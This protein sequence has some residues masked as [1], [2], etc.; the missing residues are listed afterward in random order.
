M[1]ETH[2][3]GIAAPNR[4]SEEVYQAYLNRQ[5]L[6]S[7]G[8][9]EPHWTAAGDF[10]FVRGAPGE[11][12]ILRVNCESGEATPIFDAAAVRA[13]LTAATGGEPRVTVLPFSAFQVTDSG[14]I[15]FE[16]LDSRWRLDPATNQLHRLAAD[17][18][19]THNRARTWRRWDYLSGGVEVP[20]VLSP[21]GAWFAS[22]RKHDLFLRSAR[23]S[24]VQQLTHCGSENKFWDLEAGRFFR[25][26]RERSPASPWSADSRTLFAHR[27][28]ITEVFRKP[29]IHWLGPD[30][31]V[32]YYPYQKAGAKLDRLEPTFVDVRSG[33]QI[34]VSVPTADDCYIQLLTWRPDSLHALIILYTRDLK[35][36][37]ILE[38]HRDTGAVR[39]LLSET[40]TSFVKIQHEVLG[41]EHGFELLADGGFLWL[42]TR[43][44]WNHIY[45]YDQQGNLIAQL[46]E[47]EWPVHDIVRVA[48]DGFVYFRASTDSSRPYDVHICRVSLAGGEVVQL[49]RE[50]GIHTPAFAPGGQLFVDTHS[51][52]DRPHRAELLRADGS[53]VR[54]ISEMDISGMKAVGYVPPEEFVVKAADGLT[55]LW[56]VLY[57]PADFEST[58]SY[59]ILEMIYGGPQVVFVQHGFS[60]SAHRYFNMPWALAQRGYVVVCLDA[61]GTPGRSKAFHDTVYGNWPA[62]I[63]DHAAAIRQLCA[64]NSWMDPGRVGITGFSWGGYFSICA[65]IEAPDV[66]HAAVAACPG[67]DP[68]DMILW[69]PYLGLPQRN[70]TAYDRANLVA[71]AEKVNGR[72]MLVVGTEDIW[73]IHATLK[74]TRALIDG[75]VDHELVVIPGA[76]HAFVGGEEEYFLMKLNAWFDQHVRDRN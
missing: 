65:L 42:S 20:E 45:R 13:A 27:R 59:P 9:V 57:K 25:S 48:R 51:S 29:C 35:H 50:K 30:E 18:A 49:T 73:T 72:L 39:S 47:G 8:T 52:V 11:G 19:E 37:E 44:G 3:T 76:G 53:P 61:R 71:Q 7:G 62:G 55:D 69:E 34:P 31:S 22:V 46:T 26:V 4:T 2:R 56:G 75:R 54:T 64:R 6:V 66:F 32:D 17:P 24:V 12:I 41:G 74:M 43:D 5:T 23:D 67:P 38:A 40:V 36:V 15:E 58:R 60:V 68:W 33:L 21:D 70:R 14:Q 10:W 28:D 16:Y 63:A 1:S